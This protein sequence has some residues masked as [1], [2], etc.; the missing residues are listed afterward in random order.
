M[1]RLIL[2]CL[3]LALLCGR[4]V[5]GDCE[6]NISVIPPEAGE[7]LPASVAEKLTGKLA[8]LLSAT[9]VSTSSDDLQFFF[10]GR[11]D[12]AFSE[13]TSGPDQRE[14]INTTLTLYI[15]DADGKKI[16]ASKT[17]DLKG[18]GKS[19]AQAYIKAMGPLNASRKDIVA[20]IEEGKAKIL[21]YYDKNYNTYL[22]KAR[23]AMNQRNYEE[24]LYH[25]LQIPDCC[26]GFPEAQALALE[27]Y[28]HQVDYIGQTLLAQAKAAFGADPTDKGA[29]EA[30][31]YLSQIDPQATCYKEAMA[32]GDKMQKEVKSQWEFENIQKY[33]DELAL[34]HK[35]MDNDAKLEQARI[36]SAKAIGVAWAK[37]QPTT[38][39]YYHWY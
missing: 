26:V 37:S 14:V 39:V 4:M 11:F 16:F 13:K 5:A 25:A 12:N 30:F 10:T 18:V 32:Y 2:S 7:K 9:G 35:Q 33:K 27:I 6:L 8:T 19:E 31:S 38:R 21:D 15:G 17:M 24:A 20:F 1:K 3:G 23:T 22:T 28:T 36:E 29:A 34:K